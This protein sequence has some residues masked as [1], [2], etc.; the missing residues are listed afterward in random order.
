[1]AQ[2]R[3]ILRLLEVG[4]HLFEAPALGPHVL[5][6]VEVGAVAA[7]V[8]EEVEAARA[9]EHLAAGPVALLKTQW[10]LLALWPH[11]ATVL[12]LMSTAT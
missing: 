4:Q 1:M 5:P 11:G 3:E 8:H 12:K 9:A 10:S 6:A 7:C 2:R